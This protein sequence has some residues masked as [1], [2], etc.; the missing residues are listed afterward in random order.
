MEVRVGGKV[1]V[2]PRILDDDNDDVDWSCMMCSIVLSVFVCS[3]VCRCPYVKCLLLI[4][5]K[6]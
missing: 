5:D 6:Y 2:S 4:D 3:S 1:D